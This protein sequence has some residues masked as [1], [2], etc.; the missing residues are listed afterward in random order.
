MCYSGICPWEDYPSG[1]CKGK[2]EAGL[3]DDPV[4]IVNQLNKRRKKM[5]PQTKIVALCF[6]L[7]MVVMAVIFIIWYFHYKLP[8]LK[9]YYREKYYE[10]GKIRAA[11]DIHFKVEERLSFTKKALPDNALLINSIDVIGTFIEDYISK[12]SYHS[13][14]RFKNEISKK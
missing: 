1:E 13:L 7:G 6:I 8:S 10:Y 12:N 3:C 14:K 4:F 2:K 11:K 9:N 5:N